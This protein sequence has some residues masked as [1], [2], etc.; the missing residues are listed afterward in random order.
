MMM[1]MIMMIISQN[2]VAMI[3]SVN[4]HKAFNILSD[5]Q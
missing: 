2:A 3:K 5:F 4:K 1:M